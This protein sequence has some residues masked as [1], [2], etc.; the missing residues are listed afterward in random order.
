MAKLFIANTTKQRN[1]FSFR[2]LETGKLRTIPIAPG[3]QEVVLANGSTDDIDGII[4]HHAKYGLQ[5]ASKIDQRTQFIGLCYSI[6]SPVKASVI[7]NALRD[8]DEK[9]TRDASDR[10]Q[11]ALIALDQSQSEQ[12]N[13]YTGE[14]EF[15]T[16]QARRQEDASDAP[17]IDETLVTQKR[18]KKR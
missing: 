7:E 16:T 2:A 18:G 8:N 1:M 6:D 10:R 13:G 12:N 17:R 4:R 9:L 14:M 5:D 11:A 3:T 15:S